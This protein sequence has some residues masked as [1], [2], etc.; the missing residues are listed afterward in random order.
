MAGVR[1]TQAHCGLSGR[2]YGSFAGRAEVIPPDPPVASGGGGGAVAYRYNPDR[3]PDSDERAR[4][5]LAAEKKR[6][7]QKKL[8]RQLI[9]LFAFVTDDSPPA[10]PPDA[11]P[12]QRTPPDGVA[13][14]L[15]ALRDAVSRP[16]A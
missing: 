4:E 2:R 14:R 6:D 5:W 10:P 16:P 12:M 7:R 15:A 13:G 8:R 9:Y 1:I 11:L 3:K